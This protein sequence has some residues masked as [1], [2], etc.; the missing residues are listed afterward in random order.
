MNYVFFTQRVEE[1]ESYGERRDCAD[2]NLSHFILTCG[3]CPIPIPNMIP[4]LSLEKMVT[5]I[6]PAGFILSGGNSLVK[7]GG[8]AVERDSIDR[9]CIR[10]ALARK[11]PLYG[12][13]RGMQSILDYFECS[14]RE[15]KNHVAVRHLIDGTILEEVNSYHN[16][17]ALYVDIKKPLEI[18]AQTEEGVVECVLH[19]NG[20]ILGTMWHPER[21]MPFRETDIGRVKNLF[22]Q[23]GF[24]E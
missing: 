22:G 21:E 14:L 3:Y 12:F 24:L 11:I 15:I 7:Y 10:I 19:S 20:K 4:V 6:R 17:G 23:E 13:C 9:E 2:Q 18:L 1:I 5:D 8:T 16:Q